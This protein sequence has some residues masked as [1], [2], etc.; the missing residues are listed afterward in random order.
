[1]NFSYSI[2]DKTEKL[3]HTHKLSEQWETIDWEI[4]TKEVNRLQVRIAKATV[5]NDIN[6]VKRLQ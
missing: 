2:T 1:M 3:T 5:K 6:K 4:A